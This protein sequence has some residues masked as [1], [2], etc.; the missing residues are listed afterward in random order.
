MDLGGAVL[1]R[2][3]VVPGFSKRGL[4]TVL[5]GRELRIQGQGA[6]MNESGP[7][8]LLFF[9]AYSLFGKIFHVGTR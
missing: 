6:I 4:K 2:F 7:K 5:R 9:S 3:R 1:G 8:V